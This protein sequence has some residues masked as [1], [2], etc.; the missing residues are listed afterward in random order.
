[1]EKQL[2]EKR[3]KKWF[4]DYSETNHYLRGWRDLDGIQLPKIL[5]YSL[6]RAKKF[7]W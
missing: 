5:F 6:V 7:M 4:S 2:K 3:F 1:M